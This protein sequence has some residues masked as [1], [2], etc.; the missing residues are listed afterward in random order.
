MLTVV[1]P[2]FIIPKSWHY[3]LHNQTSLRLKSALL[4]RRDVAVI[5]VPYIINE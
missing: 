3:L 5:S 4:K 1:L 2:Q